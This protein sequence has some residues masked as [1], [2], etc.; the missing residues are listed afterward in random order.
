[1]NKITRYFISIAGC[2]S[3]GALGSFFSISSIPNWYTP[4]NK[5][6]FSPPNYLFAPVWTVLYILMGVS[7]ALIWQK[8]LNA[9]KIR[10]GVS[11]FGIQLILN[12]AWSPVFFGAKNL[13]FAL[14]IIILMWI[15]ILRTILVFGKINKVPSYFFYPYLAWVSFATVLNFSLWILN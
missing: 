11:L 12:A 15:F 4:L 10:D 2:L 14:V 7:V 13:L 9:G 5:P 1:M 3:A 8:G 6:I